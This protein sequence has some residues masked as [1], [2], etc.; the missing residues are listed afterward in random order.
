[1]RNHRRNKALSRPERVV[2][3]EEERRRLHLALEVLEMEETHILQL[4]EDEGG[5]EG[6]VEGGR[7]VEMQGQGPGQVSNRVSDNRADNQGD[8]QGGLHDDNKSDHNNDQSQSLS[9]AQ[10]PA[11]SPLHGV[12]SSAAFLA[13]LQAK[14][15]TLR[16]AND[17]SGGGGGWRWG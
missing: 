4:D 11:L 17:V 16:R 2:L 7:G 1:M 14:K 3:M 12:G 15:S 10:R 9:Q 8:N 5:G 6:G 13:E